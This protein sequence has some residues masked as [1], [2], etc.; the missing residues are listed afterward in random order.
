MT[1]SFSLCLPFDANLSS[2]FERRLKPV[3]NPHLRCREHWQRVQS[4]RHPAFWRLRTRFP[5][6]ALVEL[7]AALPDG[8]RR[9]QYSPGGPPLPDATRRPQCS[10][11][12]S[13]A[14]LPDG[15]RRHIHD[16]RVGPCLRL[17]LPDGSP[18]G[19]R[20]SCGPLQTYSRS[21]LRRRSVDLSSFQRRLSP[22]SV[23][24]GAVEPPGSASSKWGFD[25]RRCCGGFDYCRS[26]CSNCCCY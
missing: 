4:S 15:K 1:C 11:G 24:R 13:P 22:E 10:P 12:G 7:Q 9:P 17:Q 26:G 20:R 18:A 6:P 8:K 23:Q 3:V 16:R 5:W 21:A 14:A 25:F 19:C 2:V